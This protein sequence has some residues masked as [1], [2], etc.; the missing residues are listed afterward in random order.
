MV[1]PQMIMYFFWNWNEPKHEK[2]AKTF[3]NLFKLWNAIWL[4]YKY[5]PFWFENINDDDG[6]I[7][8]E[9]SE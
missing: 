9:S 6:Y 8:D 4:K 2:E 7:D 1:M 5:S 3:F